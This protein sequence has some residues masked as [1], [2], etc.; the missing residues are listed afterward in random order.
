VNNQREEIRQI[1]QSLR[2][3]QARV[4]VLAW[5]ASRFDKAVDLI[6]D[7]ARVDDVIRELNEYL[8][9]EFEQ[10]NQALLALLDYLECQP[11]STKIQT[12]ELKTNI[13]E[14]R[15][16][17]L[18]RQLTRHVSNINYL[19]EESAHYG[20]SVPLSITNDLIRERDIVRD[21]EAKIKE[22]E[23]IKLSY[24]EE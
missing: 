17:S 5:I 9:E 22:F 16:A 12:G 13:V 10:V 19:E 6:E 7:F 21:I 24:E 23:A 15:L 8:I 11:G 20:P 4:D 18:R 3:L 1:Y 2:D 14:S